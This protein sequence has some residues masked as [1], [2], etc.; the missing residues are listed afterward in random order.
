MAIDKDLLLDYH[1]YFLS[2]PHFILQIMELCCLE[3]F[4]ARL[5]LCGLA[6]NW[7]DV[8][9]PDTAFQNTIMNK[10]DPGEPVNIHVQ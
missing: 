1:L 9:V 10:Y 5:L 2:N 3:R 4:W 6:L 7:S 8:S